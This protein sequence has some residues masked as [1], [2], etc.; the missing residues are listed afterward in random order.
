MQ[1]LELLEMETEAGVEMEL[2]AAVTGA[3]DDGAPSGGPGAVA[4]HPHW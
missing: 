4:K 1:L 3:E 2:L